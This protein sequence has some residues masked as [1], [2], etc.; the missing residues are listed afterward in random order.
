MYLLD[1]TGD[2]ALEA[3]VLLSTRVTAV[4]MVYS[5][6]PEGEITALTPR[7][8]ET[9][10]DKGTKLIDLDH[11]GDWEIEVTQP[12]DV[13]ECWYEQRYFCHRVYRWDAQEQI[14][15]DVTAQFPRRYSGERDFYR[16]LTV[17]R[18]AESGP[19]ADAILLYLRDVWG[20]RPG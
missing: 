2:G 15:Q 6:S 18:N 16:Q 1:L 19:S 14:F 8:L 10:G 5:V 4:M 3:V 20:I 13:W 7:G 9:T 12:L 17:N 11:D